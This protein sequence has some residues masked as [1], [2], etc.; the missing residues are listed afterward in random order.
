MFFIGF[1]HKTEKHFFRVHVLHYFF[2]NVCRMIFFFYPHI[3]LFVSFRFVSSVYIFRLYKSARTRTRRKQCACFL[4]NFKFRNN[5]RLNFLTYSCRRRRRVSLRS[6]LRL[7]VC[8]CVC[9]AYRVKLY[10]NGPLIGRGEFPPSEKCTP[11]RLYR[12]RVILLKTRAGRKTWRGAVSGTSS[13]G[14]DAAGPQ[15]GGGRDEFGGG[16]AARRRINC[17]GH[18]TRTCIKDRRFRRVIVSAL[19]HRIPQQKP[20]MEMKNATRENTARSRS[21]AAV[22]KAALTRAGR[23]KR[24]VEPPSRFRPGPVASVA[25]VQ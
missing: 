19:R 2:S 9:A 5:N 8:V 11:T 25:S 6:T 10:Q 16:N 21:A 4:I 3:S 1:S 24:L 7:C 14:R 15:G 13:Q 20:K 22:V 12:R 17:G 18:Y 23:E